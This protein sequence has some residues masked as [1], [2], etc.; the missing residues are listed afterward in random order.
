MDIASLPKADVESAEVFL[1]KN[2]DQKIGMKLQ[3]TNSASQ[4]IDVN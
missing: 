4:E 3:D 2:V 1:Y